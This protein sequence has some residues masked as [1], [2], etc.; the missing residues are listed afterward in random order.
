MISNKKTYYSVIA[1]F[2]ILML[3]LTSYFYNEYI[4]AEYTQ[5]RAQAEV[6][7]IKEFNIKADSDEEARIKYA[8]KQQSK[9]VNGKIVLDK[10][11]KVESSNSHMELDAGLVKIAMD[12]E[13]SWM[14][15]FKMIFTL[16]FTFFGVK[17]I[18]FGFAKFS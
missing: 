3:S 16:L 10:E 15:I 11:I 8:Q 4:E 7:K 18:N 14:A 12:N 5:K 6:D 13:P 2:V 1:I 17:A 9:I